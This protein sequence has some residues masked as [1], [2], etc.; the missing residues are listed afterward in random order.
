M[1]LDRECEVR[2]D[3]EAELLDLLAAVN[4][5]DL[6]QLAA[7]MDNDDETEEKAWLY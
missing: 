5:F 1:I 4:T 2:V 6:S 3:Y 7:A